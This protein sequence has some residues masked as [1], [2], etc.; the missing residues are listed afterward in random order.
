MPQFIIQEMLT[1]NDSISSF[2]NKLISKPKILEITPIKKNKVSVGIYQEMLNSHYSPYLKL[3]LDEYIANL[4]IK[5]L[6]KSTLE[7]TLSY[8]YDSDKLKAANNFSKILTRFN[9]ILYDLKIEYF[10]SKNTISDYFIQRLFPKFQSYEN[11][12][13]K[14]LI[15]GIS[16]TTDKDFKNYF[17]DNDN[18]KHNLKA[19]NLGSLG[20]GELH[21]LFFKINLNSNN[22]Y[23][24]NDY[25]ENINDLSKEQLIDLIKKG[26]EV[27]LWSK[28]FSKYIKYEANLSFIEKNYNT[29]K[30]YRNDVMHFHLID[31][32]RF[33]K[34]T[35]AINKA[36]SEIK[37]IEEHLYDDWEVS[38]A[39]QFTNDIQEMSS[40]LS[41]II[42]D[43]PLFPIHP[44]SQ[45]AKNLLL[46][47]TQSSLTTTML[48]Q[49][50]FVS[51]IANNLSHVSALST[52]SRKYLKTIKSQIFP[53]SNILKKSNINLTSNK[54]L[55]QIKGENLNNKSK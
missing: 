35:E 34:M 43:S 16:P 51:P 2:K 41:Q 28:Y 20:I 40:R 25:F 26:K 3:S 6:E 54:N 47:S 10:T 37:L 30:D 36:N 8:K 1:Y 53:I 44:M 11:G 12:L 18:F 27:N 31:A 24:N 7:I 13:R 15:L 9:A 32:K 39:N 17:N 38:T 42:K 23:Y 52:L 33:H 29:I 5:K 21:Q 14:L 22:N 19:P 4:F 46:T 49:N 48:N 45:L 50:P 55:K